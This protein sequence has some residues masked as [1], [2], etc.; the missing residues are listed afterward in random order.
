MPQNKNNT[1]ILAIAQKTLNEEAEALRILGESLGQEFIE[2]INLLNK[3]KSR[4]IVT[5]VG[6]SGHVARKIAA[7]LAST[8]TPAQFVHAAEAAHGDLGMIT[9][10][11]AII[12][13]SKSGKTPELAQIIDYSTLSDIPLIAITENPTS[14][15][16]TAATIVLRLPLIE[17]ACSLGLA[18]TTSTSMS[19]ALGDAIA[20][21]LLQRKGFSKEDFRDL[22]PGGNL[23][24]LLKRA[25]EVMHRGKDMPIVHK[26]MQMQSAIIAMAEKRF[27]CIGVTD[28]NGV[29]CGLI[30]DGD[31]RRSMDDEFWDDEFWSKPCYKVMTQNPY[32]VSPDTPINAILKVMNEKCFGVVFVTDNKKPVGIVHIHDILRARIG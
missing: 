22:H 7:T 24:N 10:E 2:T 30:T 16:A 23:G 18:P 12:A 29:F 17:E 8:G 25:S 9:S 27:G 14:P 13:L 1:D 32:V 26:D 19:M 5:G 11:D 28:D 6:K 3:I 15:L 4:I 21:A 20:I 31:L